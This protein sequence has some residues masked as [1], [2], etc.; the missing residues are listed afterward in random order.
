[1]IHKYLK[2]TWMTIFS[3]FSVGQLLMDWGILFLYPPLP[4]THILHKHCTLHTAHCLYTTHNYCALYI[5][6]CF[7]VALCTLHSVLTVHTKNAQLTLQ[8]VLH[9][10]HCTTTTS[11]FKLPTK[12]Q[13][14]DLNTM[15]F[16]LCNFNW[17]ALKN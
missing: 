3:L 11:N 15:N 8:R 5:A 13:I 17:L 6:N 2:C 14:P 4:C 7:H 9:T 1:M 10:E 12:H 16:S